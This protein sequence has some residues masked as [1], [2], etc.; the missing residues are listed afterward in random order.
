MFD[1]LPEHTRKYILI[2]IILLGMV[3]VLHGCG[4]VQDTALSQYFQGPQRVSPELVPI[5]D[6]FRADCEHY[7]GRDYCDQRFSYIAEIRFAPTTTM[8]GD[9]E[10]I[11]RR[12]GDGTRYVY[13]SPKVSPERWDDVLYHELGHCITHNRNHVDGTIMRAAGVP[14]H[15]ATGTFED[16][17]EWMFTVY[18]V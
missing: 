9:A 7:K 15:D 3:L 10:G 5:V 12:R 1:R 17:I 11:C 16:E 2:G 14:D 18:G 13:I 6:E 4:S 8:S